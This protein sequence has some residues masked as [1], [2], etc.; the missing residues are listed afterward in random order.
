MLVVGSRVSMSVISATGGACC[1]CCCAGTS[2]ITTSDSLSLCIT[3]TGIGRGGCCGAIRV[4]CR[5]ARTDSLDFRG[6]ASLVAGAS[7]VPSGLDLAPSSESS[8]SHSSGSSTSASRSAAARQLGQI[9]M[10]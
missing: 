10:G 7:K 4:A 2:T 9:K 1:C 6:W 3:G 8:C 5:V